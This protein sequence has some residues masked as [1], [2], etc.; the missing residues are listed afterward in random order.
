MSGYVG[1]GLGFLQPSGG[2]SKRSPF[3]EGGNGYGIL[4]ERTGL[5]PT[6]LLSHFFVLA[7]APGGKY[8]ILTST[9]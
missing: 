7:R 8:V 6:M 4:V 9:P 3:S 5:S 1:F 2:G